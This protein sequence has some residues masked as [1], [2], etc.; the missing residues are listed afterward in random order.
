MCFFVGRST[1]YNRKTGI[2]SVK[3]FIFNI[4]CLIP[5]DMASSTDANSERYFCKLIRVFFGH[6]EREIDFLKYFQNL[7]VF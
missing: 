7:A 4:S 6:R 5:E 3:Y 1:L 2:D